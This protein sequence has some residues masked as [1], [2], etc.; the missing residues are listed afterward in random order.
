MIVLTM[1]LIRYFIIAPFYAIEKISLQ[2]GFLEFCLMI[3]SIVLITAG[4][5]IINDIFDK[6][7]DT[8]NKPEKV[9]IDNYISTNRAYSIYYIINGIAVLIGFYLGFKAK[10]IN[11]GLI[12]L[13]PVAVFYFYSLKYKRLF[14][15][16]NIA[17]AFL[18]ASLIMLVWLFEFFNI[19]KNE[20][21]FTE[22]IQVFWIISFFILSYSF[23]AFITTLLREIIKDIEDMEGDS[24]WGCTTLPIVV[25]REK[26]K[27]IAAIISVIGAFS[28][29]FFQFMLKIINMEYLAYL[30]IIVVQ[31]PFLYLA[32]KLWKATEK[33]EFV[34]LGNFS[35]ILIL[36]GILTMIGVKYSIGLW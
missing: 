34:F 32:I 22:G 6:S 30:L 26:A 29:I 10:S 23:F 16:G 17:V 15:R 36:L 1:F 35:K 33:E 20:I 2:M 27:R 3:L 5:Y 12:F 7:I 19:K 24:K 13:V 4:G 18:T 14:L 21:I 31:I 9:F 8:I 25:G 11:L 28:V